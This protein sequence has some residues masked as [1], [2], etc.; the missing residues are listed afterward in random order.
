MPTL[1]LVPLTVLVGGAVGIATAVAAP[2]FV[3]APLAFVGGVLAGSSIQDKR[4]AKRQESKDTANRVSGAFSA[5]YEK[6][7][8]LVDPV[9]LS[10]V[11]NVGVDQSHAFLT[12]LAESTNGNSIPQQGGVGVV[13]NFPHAANALEEL[14]KNAQNW[15]QSRTAQLSQ[16]LELHQQAL[17]AA[18]LAQAAGPRQQV[19]QANE[20]VWQQ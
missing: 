14:S 2:Q 10:F 18:Q 1:K 13:F 16:Q 6:N 12:A 17:R 7:R 9:E 19:R 5:L 4:A 3:G 15:A 11:A 8:G 20:D